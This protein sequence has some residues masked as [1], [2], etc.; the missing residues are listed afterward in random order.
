MGNA[1]LVYRRTASSVVLLLSL[2]LGF[3]AANPFSSASSIVRIILFVVVVLLIVGIL[4]RT[5]LQERIRVASQAEPVKRSR[6]LKLVALIAPIL[7]AALAGLMVAYGY[8]TL[9]LVDNTNIGTI[10]RNEAEFNLI[11][12]WALGEASILW[13]VLIA[14]AL[15]QRRTQDP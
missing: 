6:V 13:L 8:D 5:Y 10:D 15:S 7:L 1:D 9:S 14:A 12:F 3:E 2:M 4:P 11:R